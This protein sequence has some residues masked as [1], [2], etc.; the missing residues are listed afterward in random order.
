MTLARIYIAL[1]AALLAH[2][3]TRTDRALITA[4]YWTLS[5]AG[6]VRYTPTADASYTTHATADGT[7]DAVAARDATRSR[8]TRGTTC[9][10][11]VTHAVTT[12]HVSRSRRVRLAWNLTPSQRHTAK[13]LLDSVTRDALAARAALA[14]DNRRRGLGVAAS[15]DRRR[16]ARFWRTPDAALDALDAAATDA[17]RVAWDSEA[18]KRSGMVTAREARYAPRGASGIAGVRGVAASVSVRD[19]YAPVRDDGTTTLR[20]LRTVGVATHPA[21]TPRDYDAL[22][23]ACR[24]HPTWATL[25]RYMPGPHGYTTHA[26]CNHVVA[27][28]TYRTLADAARDAARQARTHGTPDAARAVAD[29]REAHRLDLLASVTT[30]TARELSA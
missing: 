13:L 19:A 12:P 3:W 29:A 10:G 2:V 30:H 23:L 6:T 11:R 18:R 25:R 28:A 26:A 5:G 7:L 8:W 4:W 17:A 20:Q 14:H 9:L 24:M 27:V 15:N 16:G 21:A 1:H 22:L